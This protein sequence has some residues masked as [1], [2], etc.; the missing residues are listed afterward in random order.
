MWRVPL[1][2]EVSIRVFGNWSSLSMSM[3]EWYFIKYSFQLWGNFISSSFG[4]LCRND[5]NSSMLVLSK[6]ILSSL[7]L[8][9]NQKCMYVVVYLIVDSCAHDFWCHFQ[10]SSW[11]SLEQYETILKEVEN[12]KFMWRWVRTC[13]H[14]SGDELELHIPYNYHH[15]LHFNSLHEYEMWSTIWKIRCIRF[16]SLGCVAKK[17]FLILN[18]FQLHKRW[19]T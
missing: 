12:V 18:W 5:S 6:K 9:Y 8:V 17:R 15:H 16:Q 4:L 10:S 2:S 3:D 19:C 11:C 7:K 13:K 1:R 14:H